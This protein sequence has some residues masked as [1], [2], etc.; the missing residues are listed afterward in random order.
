VCGH[1]LP[2][3]VSRRGELILLLAL[4]H[5][6]NSQW[7]SDLWGLLHF[8]YFDPWILQEKVEW[9]HFQQFLYWGISRFTLAILTIAIDLPTLKHQFIRPLALALLWA[10]HIS[11][12]TIAISDLEDTLIIQGLDAMSG[13]VHTGVVVHRID[14]EMSGLVE[15]PWLQLMCCTV[16]LPHGCNFWCWEEV[17]DGSECWMV[18]RCWTPEIKF[19]KRLSL[20]IIR[21]ANYSVTTSLIYK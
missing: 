9:P 17:W 10:S 16:C 4:Q 20:L 15:W 5:Q 7:F 19:N 14:L 13:M 1:S 6:L 21:L 12:H 3:L 18:C 8:T 11:I 2:F